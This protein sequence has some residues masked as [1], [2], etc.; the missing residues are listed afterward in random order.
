MHVLDFLATIPDNSVDVC[1]P[2]PP[3]WGLRTYDG[4]QMRVWGGDKEC[5]HGWTNADKPNT[6]MAKQGSTETKKWARLADE[7]PP[8]SSVSAFCSH[9]S[10]WRGALGAEPT[11]Q[12]F[13]THLVEVFEEVRR[14]LKPSGI[15][16]INIGD[17]YNGS[18][19]VGNTQGINSRKG[20]MPSYGPKYAEGL[21]PKDLC[22]VPQR[23]AIA[24][25]DAG[26]WVRS[27]IAWVKDSAMPEPVKD[28]P[29]TAKETILLLSKSQ[30][31]F[32]DQEAEREGENDRNIR[33]VWR[34]NPKPSDWEYCL[35][36]S[37]LFVG[38]ERKKIIQKEVDEDIGTKQA[39]LG[40]QTYTGF[41]ERWSGTEMKQTMPVC[42]CG[43]SNWIQH[44][45]A[46][47]PRL[48]ERMI[49][50]GSSERGCCSDCGAPWERV[51][52]RSG[53]ST[54]ESWHDHEG[55]LTQGQ[56]GGTSREGWANGDYNRQTIG[57]RAT[58]DHD[59]DTVPSIV[60]DPFMGSGTTA[61]A[62]EHLGRHWLGCDLSESYC[63]VIMAR[64]QR[65][66]DQRGGAVI[67]PRQ[68]GLF[69]F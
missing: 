34:I 5:D 47:P 62:A 40:K 59:A 45:A 56:R 11:P 33:N 69:E 65:E 13:V 7:G 20:K 38:T 35:S 9:C 61:I 43:E 29:S 52:E 66:R 16:W 60:L 8:Q 39:A 14:V 63:R 19:G 21:K 50:L 22:L 25:Q 57:W 15:C 31:Y 67:A 23:L 17:S 32:Y 26:W 42:P 48:V 44:F 12:L 36:C 4:S 64:V 24:L 58:C 30:K 1:P 10:A 18:G 37:S 27:D 49:K 28:R 46:F 41:N 54:G 51:V 68:V 6:K 53:G 2:S 55:R 3:Y